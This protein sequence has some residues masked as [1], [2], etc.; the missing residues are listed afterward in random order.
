M[1][2]AR[3]GAFPQWPDHLHSLLSVATGSKPCY[4]ALQKR[5]AWPFKG[6]ANTK[7]TQ[8][9]VSV[10]G[11]HLGRVDSRS[12][13][14]FPRKICPDSRKKRHHVA[15]LCRNV[16]MT[17]SRA[18]A[19]TEPRHGRAVTQGSLGPKAQANS[20]ESQSASCLVSLAKTAPRPASPKAERSALGCKK[21]SRSCPGRQRGAGPS[22][23]SDGLRMT[24]AP[25]R[26]QLTSTQRGIF[27][28]QLTVSGLFFGLSVF[29]FD[30]S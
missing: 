6:K 10:L 14:W 30:S 1:L 25:K 29:S 17:P 16:M 19:E 22:G 2:R 12:H 13:V 8:L 20:Y 28:Q 21:C 5:D 11:P 3:K 24:A 4:H 18:V 7:T 15:T 27:R 9:Q 23:R 26:T